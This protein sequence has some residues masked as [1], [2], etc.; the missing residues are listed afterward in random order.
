MDVNGKKILLWASVGGLPLFLMIFILFIAVFLVLGM[1]SSDDSSGGIGSSYGSGECGFTISSTSL[2]KEEYINKLV[3]YSKKDSKAKVFAEN[4]GNIYDLALSSNINPELVM[5]R[6]VVEGYDPG[7]SKNNYWGLGCY[8]GKGTS[9]CISYGTFMKGVK[10]YIDNIS[11]YSSLIDMMSKYA[12]IGDKWVKG[13]SA[14]GG[15]YYFKYIK[16]YY[17]NT[18]EAQRSM[19]R[20]KSAC[21]AGGTGIK[22]TKHDQDAYA[23]WQVDANMSGVRE[24]IFGLTDKNSVCSGGEISASAAEIIKLSQAD[25]WK[26]L[27]GTSS[28]SRR[29]YVSKDVISKRTTTIEIPYRAWKSGKGKNPRTDTEKKH[30]KITVNKA[31]ADLWL[32]FFTDVYNEATDFVIDKSQTGCYN[33]R[34]VTSGSSLSAHAYGVAC[35]VNWSVTQNGYKY[36]SLNKKSWSSLPESRNKYQIIYKGSKVMEIAHRY[37]LINGSDWNSPNDSM[38]FSFIGDWTRSQAQACQGKLYC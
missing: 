25:A 8:N 23:R 33:Y 7:A 18:P 13:D 21:N 15:C 10:G 1:F 31:L 36:T 38:H 35:D 26:L 29:P 4:A 28:S 17:A 2:S 27:I 5:I 6:A 32:A 20:A 34:A 16:D 22:T 12:Y 24:T 11:K 30:M 14:N 3:E 37:T 9:A 19:L